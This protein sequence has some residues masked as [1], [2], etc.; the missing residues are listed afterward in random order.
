MTTAAAPPDAAALR[1]EHDALARR[2]ESR[3]SIDLVRKGVYLGFATFVAL[4]LAGGFAW[5]RWAFALG[6]TRRGPPAP[7]PEGAPL[8]LV[9]A[10]AGGLV[11]LGFTVRT[12]GAARRCMRVEDADF[13][14]FRALRARLGLDS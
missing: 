9:A 14:R 5:D 2:L 6:W 13:E 4:G 8:F 1:A 7:R 3:R 11:L 12:F 10:L